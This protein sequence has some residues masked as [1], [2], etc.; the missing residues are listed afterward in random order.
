MLADIPV[1]DGAEHR[2][3]Q[4]MKADIRIRMV[5]Y[6]EVTEW[7]STGGRVRAVRGRDTLTFEEYEFPTSAVLNCAGPWAAALGAREDRAL[8]EAFHP[9]LAFNLLFD[10]R[11]DSTVSVAVEPAAGGPTYFLHP[12]EDLTMAGTVHAPAGSAAEEPDEAR[13]EAFLAALRAAIPDFRVE[14]GDVLRVMS[15]VLPAATAGSAET[16]DRDL[17]H[18]AAGAGGPDGV[19]SLVGVKYTTAPLVAAAA[20]R[21]AL[22]LKGAAGPG[23]PSPDEPPTRDV[24]DWTAFGLWADRDPEAAGALLDAIVSEE[25]VRRVDDLLLRRTDWGLDP[26][27][28][29]RAD[30]RVRQLRPG[31]FRDGR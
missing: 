29:S 10:R 30:A 31:L 17:W 20:A 9:S 24:P 22:R 28:R 23:V 6:L 26:R 7:I 2:I 15:G 12:M 13:I 11:L 18:A 8:A 4:G 19:Y 14:R 27:E 3:R 21:R 25:R 5:N 1:G 16:L